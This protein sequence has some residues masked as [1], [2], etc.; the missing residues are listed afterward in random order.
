M[1]SKNYEIK[2]VRQKSSRSQRR[3]CAV[4]WVLK[5]FRVRHEKQSQAKTDNNPLI[6][7]QK[8]KKIAIQE[9]FAQPFV[10]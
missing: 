1:L 10:Q 3:A 6:C 2:L 5:I 4:A 8:P 9:K 7:P